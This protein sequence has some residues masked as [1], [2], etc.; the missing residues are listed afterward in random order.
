[1]TTTGGGLTIP[2]WMR[3]GVDCLF[4]FTKRDAWKYCALDSVGDGLAVVRS[5]EGTE[6]VRFYHIE[7]VNLKPFECVCE[8]TPDGYPVSELLLHSDR[9]PKQRKQALDNE[10]QNKVTYVVKDI[11]DRYPEVDPDFVYDVLLRRGVFK[12][13]AV[14]R[15]LIKLK[16]E[17]QGQVRTIQLALRAFKLM[18]RMKE[19]HA[20]NFKERRLMHKLRGRLSRLEECRKQLKDLCHSSR[21]Q[22]PD[23]DFEA[24]RWL[25]RQFISARAGHGKGRV[26]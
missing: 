18:D 6:S 8:M 17:W 5:E 20:T 3:S 9:C 22:A 19:E 25:K 24:Q 10:R 1:M 26:K 21:R 15:D 7:W 14:R 16:L 12:W 11:C 13:L 23:H 4:R 2:A